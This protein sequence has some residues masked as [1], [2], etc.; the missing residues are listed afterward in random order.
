MN[1]GMHMI[2]AQALEM[3]YALG[4]TSNKAKKKKN[5]GAALFKQTSV[6]RP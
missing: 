2:S 6:L 5:D 3:R 4:R 1:K